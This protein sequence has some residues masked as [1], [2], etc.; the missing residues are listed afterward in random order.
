MIKPLL[1]V[2][3]AGA[4]A[5]V[6]LVS[7]SAQDG[8]IE[9][10]WGRAAKEKSSQSVE[11]F[12][13]APQRES[14]PSWERGRAQESKTWRYADPAKPGIDMYSNNRMLIDSLTTLFC[15]P[16]S[17]IRSLHMRNDLA[18]G[19]VT[20]QRPSSDFQY[21]NQG[22]QERAPGSSTDT[23]DQLNRELLRLL[24]QCIYGS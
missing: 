18:R 11:P 8:S 15:L 14:Y 6:A 3:A 21:R 5:L 10:S 7:A 16:N 20:P 17:Y 2:I 13:P 4:C 24:E 1:K 22:A 9:Q 12:K 19:T 23:L